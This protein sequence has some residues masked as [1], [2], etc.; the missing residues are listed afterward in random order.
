LVF[1]AIEAVIQVTQIDC[2]LVAGGSADEDPEPKGARDAYGRLK[3]TVCTI[4]CQR[5]LDE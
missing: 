1:A 2:R 5:S 3:Q 4:E